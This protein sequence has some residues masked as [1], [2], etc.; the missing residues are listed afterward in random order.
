[1]PFDLQIQIAH[2]RRA[3]H[4]ISEY[5]LDRASRDSLPMLNWTIGN[6]G[7]QIT[8]ISYAHPSPRRRDE[9]TAWA[10]ALNIQLSEHADDTVTTITGLAEDVQTSFGL[11]TI[12]LLCDVY[13]DEQQT[14]K[15]QTERHYV[16][17]A[18]RHSSD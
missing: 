1:M 8:G 6:T 2:Q 4:V 12:M 9:I 18:G 17:P 15:D 14:T 16:V 3:A 11:A 13:H 7:V 10:K 5:L